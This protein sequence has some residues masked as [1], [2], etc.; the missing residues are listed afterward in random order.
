[1]KYKFRLVI[2]IPAHT[3][4]VYVTPEGGTEQT[5]GTDFAFRTEQNTVAALNNWA[6]TVASATG[7]T[8]VC[9]F[10]LQ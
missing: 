2:N 6:V 10:R 9:D 5:V 7:S 1:V 3:Y 4:S 8:T